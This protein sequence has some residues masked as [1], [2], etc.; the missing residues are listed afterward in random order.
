MV[1]CIHE[2]NVQWYVYVPGVV[3]VTVKLWPAFIISGEFATC[4]PVGIVSHVT[5]C[6]APL[7][8]SW[9][10]NV[11]VVPAATVRFSG[12]KFSDWSAPTFCGITTVIAEVELE[13]DEDVVTEPD[14]D[15]ELDVDVLFETDVLL[16]SEMDVLLLMLVEVVLHDE[17][18]MVIPE[19]ELEP[20]EDVVLEPDMEVEL[21]PDTDEHESDV[22]LLEELI[23]EVLFVADTLGLEELMI[24][25][26]E[27]EGELLVEIELSVDDTDV[28][29]DVVVDGRVA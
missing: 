13:P 1:P 26:F 11:M 12:E 23:M 3:S 10:T 27:V 17:E 7:W 24:E 22:L 29:V 4:A 14:V 16:L 20:D 5:L 9:S 21:E 2:W 15:T 18:E 19:L 25:V 6:G 8:L 28:D